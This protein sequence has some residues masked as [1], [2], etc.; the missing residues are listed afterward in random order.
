MKYSMQR[1]NLSSTIKTAQKTLYT[2]NQI[3]PIINQL[4]PIIHN[5]S[6]AFKVAKAVKSFDN[7]IDKEIDQELN[8][9]SFSHMINNEK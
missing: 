5:A 7:D 8:N 9:Q 1:L 3:I 6:T 2:A 4:K